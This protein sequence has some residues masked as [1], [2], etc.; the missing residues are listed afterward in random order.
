MDTFVDSS[1]YYLRYVDHDNEL[2]PFDS[3]SINQLTPVDLYVGG[4]EHGRV[5]IE[6]LVW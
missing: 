3:D 2:K 6:L 5:F 4:K 1:W